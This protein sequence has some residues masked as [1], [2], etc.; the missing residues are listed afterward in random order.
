[1]WECSG[2]S[3][4]AGD[5]SLATTIKETREE[6]GIVLEPKNG[7][8]FTRYK[9]DYYDNGD[10][11]DVWLFRQEVDISTVIFNPEETWDAIWADKD[12]INEM[13]DQKTFIGRD[14]FPYIDELFCFCGRP[15]TSAFWFALNTLVSE[16]NIV[17][18]RPKGSAH[19]RYPDF[20]YPLDYGYLEN[21]SSMDGGGID[22]WKGTTGSNIN[23]IICTVDLLKRDSEIKIL[24]GCGEE[25]TQQ[26]LSFLNQ[27]E[28]MKA[29]LISRSLSDL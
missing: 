6:L 27:S 9:R 8:L 4:V 13:I 7:S 15:E 20:I 11:V 1:M 16:S 5:G 28:N 21:T 19:T 22:V 12:K 2:G 25:E 26:V 14:I 17:I 24:I 29:I 10:F 23:A 18:D 3:A